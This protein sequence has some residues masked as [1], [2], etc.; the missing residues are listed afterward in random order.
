[1]IDVQLV[2]KTP[3][4]FYFLTQELFLSDIPK[5]TRKK[6]HAKLEFK[7]KGVTKFLKP[8]KNYIMD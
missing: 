1:M 7:A 2:E 4:A 8:G 5:R 3:Q 6:I